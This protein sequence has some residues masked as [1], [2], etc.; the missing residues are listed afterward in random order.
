[1]RSVES[2]LE[3]LE[4]ASGPGLQRVVVCLPE[5]EGRRVTGYRFGRHPDAEF[6]KRESGETLDAFYARVKAPYEDDDHVLL[7]M[8]VIVDAEDGKAVDPL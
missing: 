8:R 6:L 4:A 1:M 2:R 3:R 5:M 7:I